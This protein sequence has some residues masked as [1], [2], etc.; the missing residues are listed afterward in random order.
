PAAGGAG[1]LATRHLLKAGH[2]RIAYLHWSSGHYSQKHREE[3]YRN[4]MESAGLKPMSLLT[5]DIHRTLSSGQKNLPWLIGPERYTAFVCYSPEVASQLLFLTAMF[6]LRVHVDLSAVTFADEPFSFL[7][8]Q[9]D[10]VVLPYF[11]MGQEA[12]NMLLQKIEEPDSPI[13]PRVLH[14]TIHIAGA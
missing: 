13:V 14:P 1:R 4:E 8:Y 11:E 6:G 3:G 7:G 12:V 2:R 10:T 9:L 5:F